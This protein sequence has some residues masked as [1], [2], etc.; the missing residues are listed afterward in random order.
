MKSRIFLMLFVAVLSL[1]LAACAR[2]VARIPLTG[3]DEGSVEFSHPGG[4][5]VLWTDLNVKFR[6]RPFLQYQVQF[7]QQGDL[8]AETICY[9]LDVNV[10]LRKSGSIRRGMTS[11]KYEGR[12][13]CDVEL[14]AGT[15]MVAAHFS[16]DG[17]DVE[18]S[19][20]DLVLKVSD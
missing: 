2:E 7:H 19:K 5:I 20:N 11:L 14:P 12:M 13:K 1:F 16:M 17:R 15:Y 10:Y 3:A 18:L 6:D 8:V 9:P 4:R